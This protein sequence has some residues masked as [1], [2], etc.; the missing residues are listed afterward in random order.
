MKINMYQMLWFFLWN[1]SK[2]AP[3]AKRDHNYVV[4]NKISNR[5]EW[6]FSIGVADTH[7]HL[8]FLVYGEKEWKCLFASWR[9]SLKSSLFNILPLADL[10]NSL[11]GLATWPDRTSWRVCN[12]LWW[13]VWKCF[14]PALSGWNCNSLCLSLSLSLSLTV[15]ACMLSCPKCFMILW[16]TQDYA[17]S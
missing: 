1:E 2:H 12:P 13:L 15:C 16:G 10:T 3:N 11:A 4:L 5:L 17:N 7:F 8:F 14:I 6:S 9:L